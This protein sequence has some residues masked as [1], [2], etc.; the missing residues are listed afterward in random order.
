MKAWLQHPTVLVLLVIL[1]LLIACLLIVAVIVLV[2]RAKKE[3]EEDQSEKTLQPDE[4]RVFTTQ[5]QILY[6]GFH[7]AVQRLRDKTPGR[8][9][10]YAVPWYLLLGEQGSGKSAVA[11]ALS[12]AQTEWVQSPGEGN[13][14]RWLLLEQAVLVD[15]P[16]ETFLSKE[17]VEPAAH[18]ILPS[19]LDR[20]AAR[21]DS[22]WRGFLQL[23]AGYRPRQPLNGVVLTVSAI[24]LLDAVKAPDH[25]ARMAR[26]AHLGRRLNEIQGATGLSL[27]VYVLVTHSE[28]LDG[29]NSYTNAL[30]EHDASR[31]MQRS[32]SR[33]EMWDDIFG[34]SNPYS[35]E[36]AFDSGW[37]EEAFNA[38]SEVLLHRQMEILAAS[39]NQQQAE[40]ALLF[41][42]GIQQ[43]R[44]PLQS[45]LNL[46]FASTAYQASH[47]LRGIYF[48]GQHVDVQADGAILATN[49]KLA[50][51]K[52]AG[53]QRLSPTLFVRNLFGHKIFAEQ[54]LAVAV[55]RRLFR[56]N[57]SVLTAQIVAASLIVV[58]AIG[59][60]RSWARIS[61]LQS[62]TL[63]PVLQSVGQ[64]LEKLPVGSA[65]NVRPAVDL[66][67]SVG[68]VENVGYTS[69]AM[70]YSYFD[71]LHRDLDRAVEGIIGRVLIDSCKRALENRIATVMSP[72][73]VPSTVTGPTYPPGAA[74]Q[75]DPSYAALES[76]LT[77]V[78]Q[79][80]N[81]IDRYDAIS[82]AG[83]GTFVQLNALLR[84]LGGRGL[85]DTSKYARDPH[86]TQLLQNATWSQVNMTPG[87]DSATAENA[88]KLIQSFYVSWFD[89]NPLKNEVDLLT[90]PE[91]LQV[92]TSSQS[93]PT[94]EQLRSLANQALAMDNQLND[95]SFD[96]IAGTFDRESYPAIGNRLDNMS[97]ANSQF[98]NAVEINGG[99]ELASLQLHLQQ[100]GVLATTDGR[101]RLDGK[102]RTLASVLNALLQ[103]DLMANAEENSSSCNALPRAAAWNQ[104]DLSKA[105]Q[106]EA[107]REKIEGDL[108]PSLPQNY[109]VQV[110]AVV[111]DRTSNAIYAALKRAATEGAAGSVTER[112]LEAA[113]QNFDQSVDKLNLIDS[114]LSNLHASVDVSC[115][116]RAMVSQAEALLAQVNQ[117]ATDL[118]MHSTSGDDGASGKPTSEWLFGV[119]SPDELQAY[120]ATERQTVIALSKEAT[121]LVTL[122]HARSNR[123]SA[124]LA[125]W[126]T[127]SHDVEALQTK[128][129]GNI[130][131]LEAFITDDL[132][133][134]TPQASC[135]PPG[136]S[137][138]NDEFLNVR[139]DLA[140]VGLERCQRL[141][142]AR[143]NQIAAAFNSH[144]AGRF[145]F[146]QNLDTR[147]GAEASPDDIAAFYQLFDRDGD[148]LSGTLTT[149]SS[150]PSQPNTFLQSVAEAR[151]LVSG[152]GKITTPA[153]AIQV[154]F[155]TNRSREVLGNRIAEWA[156]TVGQKTVDSTTVSAD[157]PPILWQYGQPVTLTLR[158]ANN[159]QETPSTTNPSAFVRVQDRTVTYRYADPWALLTFLQ[160]HQS[161]LP[162][163]TN[164]YI[165]R[166]PN[167]SQ[168]QGETPLQ[169][170]VYMQVEL[171]S[172]GG[173]D[174]SPPLPLPA[175][176]ASAP[177]ATLKTGSGAWR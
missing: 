170:T 160:D 91:G 140:R 56:G 68:V 89:S 63:N 9:Y 155:R 21:H 94:N 163:V 85:P 71:T 103:Y 135:K 38:T 153:V 161:D 2:L 78:R 18:G 168:K 53:L 73:V 119:S 154:Q 92:L 19:F 67:N 111:D 37:V 138:S 125:K 17:P 27:P 64:S 120:L 96:W 32:D 134:I 123:S 16:G 4:P 15:V 102:V 115:L 101:V 174:G 149:A 157:M 13:E 51:T 40:D 145:P 6:D 69:L 142:V 110:K 87:Y 88:N 128:K 84:Y 62:N 164:Q 28:V 136:L 55:N 169:T 34:W 82:S 12:G 109:R 144:L 43:L 90:G 167:Q 151:P 54:F 35:L 127:I 70:P 83:Y 166:I 7:R 42:F 49:G 133:K 118:Y 130:Q 150:N 146:S 106:I 8:D 152:V 126:Q 122:L 177:V 79:L 61:Q 77:D 25:S 117:Q 24:E 105:I 22:P 147:P 33:E 100:S 98:T 66:L 172:I 173:K 72:P 95:G 76:Y 116:N 107:T 175:F 108:L 158:Y 129:P 36:R 59:F 156:L 113:L 162:G 26:L 104:D 14:P 114:S 80:N 57:R 165:F 48:C 31:S 45:L 74:W 143:F 86:Y 39:K 58:I 124:V 141:S 93:L 148:G 121:P 5:W 47:M 41:P 139:S 132:D 46:V 112:G 65:A 75:S 99:R 1:G 137:N 30:L 176:P 50:T 23:I 171:L 3:S 44:E 97:F 81:N 29:F 20:R 159:S 60:A 131:L 10:Q 52:V 11:D